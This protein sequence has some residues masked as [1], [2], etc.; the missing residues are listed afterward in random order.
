MCICLRLSSLII[1]S[2]TR[3]FIYLYILY[4]FYLSILFTSPA[5]RTHTKKNSIYFIFHLVNINLLLS[6]TQSIFTY[7]TY[8]SVNIYLFYL[9]FSHYLPILSFIQSIFI[10][11]LSLIKSIFIFLFISKFEI[12]YPC[13]CFTHYLAVLGFHCSTPMVGGGARDAP[14]TDSTLVTIRGFAYRRTHKNTLTSQRTHKV[15]PACLMSLVFQITL[16]AAT[17]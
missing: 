6:L 5:G 12:L 16:E 13:P 1:Y 4:Y 9:S 3:L 10:F 7:V 11:F 15:F 17:T 8:H 2:L 14:A